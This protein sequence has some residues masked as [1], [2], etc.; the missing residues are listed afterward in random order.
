MAE[1]N[2]LVVANANSAGLS[3][4]ER[5]ANQAQIDSILAS[6]DRIA[7]STSFTG[8]TLLD[9]TASITAGSATFDIASARS[10]DIGEVAGSPAV[11]SPWR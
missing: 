8:N 6:V 1:A 11:W 7:G 9:G 2:A 4:E 5:Q 3:D 10:S